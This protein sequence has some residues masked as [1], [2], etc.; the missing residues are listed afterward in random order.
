MEYTRKAKEMTESIAGCHQRG[1]RR[2]RLAGCMRSMCVRDEWADDEM[3][4]ISHSNLGLLS[5]QVGVVLI[6]IK[7]YK[8]WTLSVPIATDRDS[9]VHTRPAGWLTGLCPAYEPESL[10]V[11]VPLCAG[12]TSSTSPS[13]PFSP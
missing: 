9:K 13:V 5:L 12:L 2:A 7:N 11:S 10:S 8:Q 3:T 1:G 4:E 6:N